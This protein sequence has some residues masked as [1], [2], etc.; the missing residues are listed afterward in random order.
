MLPN[1]QSWNG[2]REGV[3]EVGVQG[4]AAVARPEAG[5]HGQLHQ[6]G[7]TSDVLSTGRLTARQS[8]KLIQ[9]NGLGPFRSQ[10]GVKER[11]MADLIV[12]VIMDILVHVLIQHFHGGGIGWVPGSP[13]NFAVLDAGEFVVLLPQI[14]FNEFCCRQEPKNIRVTPG[15]TATRSYGRA[16]PNNPAPMVPAPTASDLLKKERRQ[17]KLFKGL[18]LS[19]KLSSRVSTLFMA[20]SF[21]LGF[22]VEVVNSDAVDRFI[23]FIWRLATPVTSGAIA[24]PR[25][26]VVLLVRGDSLPLWR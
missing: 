13:W 15:E 23:A 5:V 7:E 17:R 9:I 24:H 25:D 21:T 6:V 12:G 19:S 26:F 10:I 4:V 20:G 16:L 11:E 14:G 8:T 1:R 22:D 18:T 2:L 3:A